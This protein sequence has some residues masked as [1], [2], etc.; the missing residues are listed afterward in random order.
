MSH[1][2]RVLQSTAARLLKI[3]LT[4]ITLTALGFV[5]KADFAAGYSAFAGGLIALVNTGI[6]SHFLRRATAVS[7]SSPNQGLVLFYSGA[8][9]R[10]IVVPLC[11]GLGIAVFEL[12]PIAMLVG[13]ALAQFGYLFNHVKTAPINPK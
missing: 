9:L 5:L 8:G 2:E 1:A 3:Q 11:F 12:T 13:F 4:I 10:F 7:S 6:S